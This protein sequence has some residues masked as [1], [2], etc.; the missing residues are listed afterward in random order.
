MTPS[1]L[2]WKQLRTCDDRRFFAGTTFMF[3][4]DDSG[5]QGRYQFAIAVLCDG[6]RQ[7]LL[8]SA[9]GRTWSNGGEPLPEESNYEG[10]PYTLSADWLRR[11]LGYIAKIKDEGDVWFAE[12]VLITPEPSGET[13]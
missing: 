8:V 13:H 12:R 9:E 10:Q 5:P 11:N 3:K 6:D 4:T 1:D 2:G 7:F